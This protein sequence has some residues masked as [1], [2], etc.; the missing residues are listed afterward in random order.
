MSREDLV[1]AYADGQVSRRVF[2]RRLTAAGVSLSAALAYAD[3]TADRPRA[4]DYGGDHYGGEDHYGHKK[5]KKDK[6]KKPK[7]PKKGHHPW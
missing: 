3:I 5:D 7:K 4:H 1:R 6:D 2:I